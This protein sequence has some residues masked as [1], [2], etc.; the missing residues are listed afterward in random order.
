MKTLPESNEPVAYDAFKDW[1][2]REMPPMTTIGNPEWW[3]KRIYERFIH[4]SPPPVTEL[5]KRQPLTDEEI[6]KVKHHMVDGAYQYSFMQGVRYAEAAH[7]IGK[8]K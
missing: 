7:G 1:M 2:V 4:T 3:A 6:R 8:H 5:H